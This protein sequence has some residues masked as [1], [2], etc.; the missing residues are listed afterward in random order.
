MNKQQALT[1]N[2]LYSSCDPS[3]FS[4]ETTA[5]L[6]DIDVVVGQQRA[7]DSVQ[8]GL[9]VR[10]DGYNIFALGPSGM[11]KLTAVKH[12]V[13][14]EARKQPIPHDWCYVY[15]FDQPHQP[16]ALT[17]PPGRGSQLHQDMAQLVEELSSAIPAAFESE[18]YRIRIEEL[19]QE[20]K[21]RQ[22]EAIEELHERAKEQHIALMRTPSGFAFTPM[23]AYDE[24]LKP[25]QFERLPKADQERIESDIEELQQALQKAMR[26]VPVWAKETREKIRDVNREIAEFSVSH[27]LEG[28]KS[29][30][31]D[32]P[33]VGDYLNAVQQDVVDNVD[34]FLPQQESPLPFI[35]QG[36]RANQLQRY[37][38]NLLVDNSALESAP[39]IFEDLPSHNNL[40]GRCEYQAQMG[41]LVTDFTLIK[42]GALHRAN[43]GYLVLDVRQVLMQPFAWDSLKRAL[44]AREIRLDSL[45]RSL[46]LISTVS[47][48]PE[49]IPLDVKV[50]LVGDRILYYMLSQYDPDFRDLFKV[51]ADFDE[52]MERSAEAYQIY[53][54]L[55]ATL[56]RHHK[57]RAL[58][59][60]A[61]ARLIEHAGRLAED[62]EKTS[63][64]LRS[65]ADLLREADH[66]A[67]VAERDTITGEDVQKTIDQQIYRA[68]R[69]RERVY[70]NIQR[71]T[72]LIDTDGSKVGQI[73][74]LSVLQLG[75]F[76]FG[77]PT[78]ITAT[79]R[80]GSGKVIDIE[81]ET[82]L[83]GSIH[84]KGV[85]ILS[86]FLAARYAAEQPLSVAASL[87]FEQS[88]G[89]VEGD[90]ASLAELC[91]LLSSLSSLPIQQC[92]AVTGSVNQHGQVQP[93]GG[94]NEKIEGFF[95]IC[96][97]RGLSGEHSV[98]IPASNVKNL[99]LKPDVVQA[100]DAGRFHIYAVETVD[101]AVELLTANTAG[102]R[103][104]DGTF[105][106]DSVNARVEAR[107]TELSE[108][109][110]NFAERKQNEEA[111]N[112]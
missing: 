97:V 3:Q 70:E 92:F 81:R 72:M 88:Y 18:D 57:L 40:I 87:V 15:N 65:M 96:N 1:T 60:G 100:A 102:E 36:Q 28:V 106:A 33:E 74:A 73:N 44:Q 104:D 6:D 50:V 29:R 91:T 27:L 107:L 77:Q 10:S 105:P 17:L 66:W 64:H 51:M 112:E 5:E 7:L 8:F 16:N 46:S 23:S 34:A 76:A 38:V 56:A 86:S 47:L 55:F 43:G 67:S 37:Q 59:C 85:L 83:G 32:L 58:D 22:T 108:L 103:N 53:A 52:T 26:Q 84:S 99:M 42:A 69:V 20:L 9:R 25:E 49:H 13:A 11:G 62:A 110:R 79:T 90:S 109:R 101:Q 111:A 35:V 71:G 68:E 95:D 39:V 89:M 61:V 93:I 45:E 41:T 78:R 24:V 54:R 80:L 2:L 75:N 19:E 12:M 48:E 14:E 30:Y 98:I 63:T 4:F 82:E 31:T 21:E 94:V